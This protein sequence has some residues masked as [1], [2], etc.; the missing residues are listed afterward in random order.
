MT[1]FNCKTLLK[2]QVAN[3]R[4]PLVKSDKSD[5]WGEFVV[6]SSK[7][8]RGTILCFKGNSA[9]CF[10]EDLK[11]HQLDWA[12]FDLESTNLGRFDLCYDRDLKESDGDPYT[13]LKECAEEIENATMSKNT[14]R[15][16]RR[17]SPSFFRVYLRKNGRNLRF[18]LEIKKAGVKKFQ[19]YLFTGQF[20]KLEELLVEYYY[21]Q[22]V[23]IFEID[24]PFSDFLKAAIGLKRFVYFWLINWTLIF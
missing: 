9:Q 18:E 7:H 4:K 12:V 11:R 10:Y 15:I 6:N 16:G 3:T 21:D 5:Y 19:H 20:E 1:R 23:Q 17:S 22:S 14:L 13:F 24:H 2:D 8:W